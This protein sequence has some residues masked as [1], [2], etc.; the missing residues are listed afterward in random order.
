[1]PERVWLGYVRSNWIGSMC[2]TEKGRLIDDDRD[3]MLVF[4]PLLLVLLLCVS[5]PVLN[6]KLKETDDDIL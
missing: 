6:M 5:S 4:R 2:A 3:C 1:M